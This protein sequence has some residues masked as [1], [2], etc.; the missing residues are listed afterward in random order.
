MTDSQARAYGLDEAKEMRRRREQLF[1]ERAMVLIRDGYSD[2][3]VAIRMRCAS[4]RVQRLR[5]AA[6]L[7]VGRCEV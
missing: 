7:P 5:V 4:S 6:G 1:R 3:L 2:T